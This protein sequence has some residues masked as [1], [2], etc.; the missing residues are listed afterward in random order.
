M[1][2]AAIDMTSTL[3]EAIADCRRVLSGELGTSMSRDLWS[4]RLAALESVR[5]GRI[6]ITQHNGDDQ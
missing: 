5:E 4:G 6:I 3:E 1:T 2:E